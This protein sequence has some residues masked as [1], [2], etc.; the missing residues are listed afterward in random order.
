MPGIQLVQDLAVIL[1]AAWMGG[2]ICHRFGISPVVVSS[3]AVI[4]KVLRETGRDHDAAGQ[5]ALGVTLLEDIVAVVVLTLLSP[6]ALKESVAGEAGA[7]DLALLLGIFAGLILLAL[8]VGLFLVPR[9]MERFGHSSNPESRSLLVSGLAFGMAILAV[10]AGTSLALG[11][12]LIGA[13]SSEYPRLPNWIR[14]GTSGRKW[15]TSPIRSRWG[16]D[17][18]P[19]QSPATVCGVG[20]RDRRSGCIVKE[21]WCR[22]GPLS[23]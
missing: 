14:P 8:V 22:D 13:I 6:L 5:S 11:A 18:G 7:P 19:A 10:Q 21:T 3:S 17:P 9:L 15:S 20:Y 4:G 1:L 2:W 12:F 23:E 16:P